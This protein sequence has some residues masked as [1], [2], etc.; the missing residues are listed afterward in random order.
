MTFKLFKPN[1][2]KSHWSKLINKI[3]LEKIRE[4]RWPHSVIATQVYKSA[5][6]R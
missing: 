5:F 6:S 2:S 4:N 1:K 3:R